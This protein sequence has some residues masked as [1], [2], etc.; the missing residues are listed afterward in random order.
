[1]KRIRI[2]F[3]FYSVIKTVNG[4]YSLVVCGIILW[5]ASPTVWQ[6]IEWWARIW[7]SRLTP[8][9]ITQCC[10][11]CLTLVNSE[12][13]GSIYSLLRFFWR[14]FNNYL[15]FSPFQSTILL[16]KR[17]YRVNGVSTM[18]SISKTT[19][20]SLWNFFFRIVQSSSASH[21]KAYSKS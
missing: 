18:I 9:P 14:S 2:D 4:R 5:P 6:L 21:G 13:R 10:I 7:T 11:Y 8:F 17:L 1:M 3:N 16:Y 15:A 12:L 20:I 19:D